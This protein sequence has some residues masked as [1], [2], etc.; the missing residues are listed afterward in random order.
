MTAYTI[1]DDPKMLR[2]TLCVAQGFV[3]RSGDSRAAEHAAR[4]G[5]LIDECDRHRPLGPDG[6]HGLRHTP[7]CG[8]NDGEQP[9]M[10]AI[11]PE[12]VEAAARAYLRGDRMGVGENS[13]RHRSGILSALTAA[14]PHIEAAMLADM[15]RGIAVGVEAA[16]KEGLPRVEAAARADERERIETAIRQLPTRRAKTWGV[17]HAAGYEAAVMDAARIARGG[18]RD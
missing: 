13:G 5:R 2:E 11:P 12:A 4:L 14:A 10:T 15:E 1:S 8:C 17:S 18:D 3:V 9:P 7:T 6:N 16:M